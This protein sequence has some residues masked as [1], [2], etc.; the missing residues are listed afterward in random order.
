MRRCWAVRVLRARGGTVSGQHAAELQ[1]ERAMEERTGVRD[2]RADLQ[3]WKLCA[4][5]G[6]DELHATEQP[7]PA[8]GV[9]LER[10]MRSSAQTRRVGLSR[11]CLQR[12]GRL[13]RMHTRN[14]DV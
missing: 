9:F 6:R 7:V 4:V 1:R 3:R 11:R 2:T 13:L 8:G 10:N 12:R 5:L 14:R